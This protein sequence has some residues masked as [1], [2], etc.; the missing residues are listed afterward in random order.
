[1]VGYPF[2]HSPKKRVKV[3]CITENDNIDELKSQLAHAKNQLQDKNK[4]FL[5]IQNK[6]L[7]TEGKLL[8]AE[9]QLKYFKKVSNFFCFKS[10]SQEP[11]TFKY[12]CGLDLEQFNLLN[13][14][15]EPY[16]ALLPHTMK[17]FDF[18]TQYLIALT[19]CQ[20]SLDFRCMAFILKTSQTTVQRILLI[21]GLFF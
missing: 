1:M 2:K 18:E 16:L 21:H 13:D 11:K 17:Y 10:L 14:I 4:E 15:V 9:Q 3:G 7:H 5:A 20:H 8:H 19:I 6:L 12:L